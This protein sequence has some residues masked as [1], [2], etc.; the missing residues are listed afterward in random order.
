MVVG[1]SGPKDLG[2]I[3]LNVVHT[4]FH[5]LWGVPTSPKD[6]C[7]FHVGFSFLDLSCFLGLVSL[8]DSWTLIQILNSI[9]QCIP[10][11]SYQHLF[12]I[13]ENLEVMKKS[14]IM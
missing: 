6:F 11:Q 9:F 4:Q 13:S 1:A 5:G 7:E 3:A 2:K 8:F 10:H 12:Y 14:S